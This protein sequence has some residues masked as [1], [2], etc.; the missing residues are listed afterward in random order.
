MPSAL[1]ADARAAVLAWFDDRG[2][3]LAFRASRDPYAI[4]VSEVMAQ[5]TQI[6]RV[7]EAWSRLLERFPTVRD[8]AAATPAD[9]LRAWRGMGYDR[10]A[11][12]L[13][14]AARVIVEE[15]DGRVPR[16]VAALE[17]LPG[18]GPY[19][20]RAVAS[21]AFGLPV[22]AVDTNVRRVLGRALGGHVTMTPIEMQAAADASVDPTRP[23]EW[24]HAVM[25][26]GAT[27]CRPGRPRCDA[28]PLQ[29]WC[30]FAAERGSATATDA[31]R[32]SSSGRSTRAVGAAAPPFRTTSRWL[33]GRIVDRLREADGPAWTRVD[34]AIGEHD[35]TAIEAA[36]AALARDGLVE[37]DPD[38]PRR[39][40]L[41]LA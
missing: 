32:G 35:A 12:N 39:A 9:V 34:P 3:D 10:R 7:V 23:G 28:C 5:Q 15:H 11:L 37:I 27:L 25:D 17:R 13:Q 26:V 30:R 1:P 6:G 4:L 19:T 38:E 31:P 41:A 21:I 33:R 8:L 16:D 18:I 20:A 40:R 2:R 22:G 36:L 29:A 14:R 24:T